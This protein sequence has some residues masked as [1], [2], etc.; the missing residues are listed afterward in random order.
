MNKAAIT[1]QTVES[2]SCDEKQS[3]L[4]L[5]NREYPAK[6]VYADLEAFEEYLGGLGMPTHILVRMNGRIVGWATKFYR[7]QDRWF[8]IILSS[9]LHR[10]RIGSLLLEHIKDHESLL[11]GWVIDHDNDFKADGNQYI[12]PLSFYLKRGFTIVEGERLEL[13]TLSAVKIVWVR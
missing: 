13:P 8:A 3:V 1:F 2:L 10:Q 7:D 5:W 9:S 12:S 11:Y 4:E 6:L